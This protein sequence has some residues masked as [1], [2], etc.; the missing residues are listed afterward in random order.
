MKTEIQTQLDS[1]EGNEPAIPMTLLNENG[2]SI[3][4]EGY[5]QGSADDGHGWPITLEC[6]EGKVQLLVWADINCEDV[7]H[8][9]DLSGAL[10]SNRREE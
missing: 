7:T 1:Y 4:L 10:E 6:Y 9:I 8:K 2:L 3:K 5:G